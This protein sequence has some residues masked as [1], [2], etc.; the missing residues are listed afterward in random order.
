MQI[1]YHLCL[2]HSLSDTNEMRKKDSIECSM[3]KRFYINLSTV[4]WV[5]YMAFSNE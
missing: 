3:Y 4:A 1:R 5:S 2:Y